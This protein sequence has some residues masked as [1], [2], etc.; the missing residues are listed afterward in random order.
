MQKIKKIEST[1]DK[2]EG[3]GMREETKKESRSQE[4]GVR[5]KAAAC[6]YTLP[7]CFLRASGF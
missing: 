1:Q 5:R 2:A 6:S 3:G 7:C 4:P